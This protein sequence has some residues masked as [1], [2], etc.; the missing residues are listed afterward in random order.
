MEPNFEIRPWGRFDILHDAP[1]CKVKRLTVEAGK[2]I[3]YQRHQHRNEH[4]VVVTGIAEVMLD[5]Q[6]Y[7]REPGETI[8]VPKMTKHRIA[9]V[10]PGPLVLIEVQLGTYFGEDDIERFEDDFGRAQ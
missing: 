7:R 3:S 2:R 1:D 5:G 4:W 6:P 8:L 9:N 10:G